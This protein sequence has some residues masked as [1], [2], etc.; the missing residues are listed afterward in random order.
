MAQELAPDLRHPLGFDIVSGAFKADPFPTLAAMRDAG[1][2]IPIRLPFVGRVWLATT[3]AACLAMVKDNELFVQEGRHAGRSGVPGFAWWLPKPLKVMTNNM[4]QKDE[5]DHR[6][7]RH[8]VDKAFA[9]RDVLAMRGGIERIADGLIDGFEGRP[10]VDLVEAYA[11]QLPMAVICDL[12][13]LTDEDR[14]EF[15]AQ[16]MKVLNI[17]SSLSLLMT[18]GAFNRML[19]HARRL[20][21]AARHAPRPGLI[22][23]LVAAEEAGDRLNAAELLSMIVLLLVAGFETTRQLIADSV[24]LLESQP[25][26]KAWLL[27]DPT[28]RMERAVEELARHASPVQMTKPRYISRDTD[29]FGVSLK[30][31]DIIMA[32]LAGA[33]SDPAVF[34][35]PEALRLDRFP[36][37]HLVFSSGVHFCLGMQLARVEAQSAVGRL[38]ARCPDL[39]LADPRRIEW[40]ERLGVRGPKALPVVLRPGAARLAA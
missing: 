20:I 6:R 12:L 9:R 33:N 15:S 8:L 13:G 22:A 2:V 25:D 27:A 32:L 18:A 14:I 16:A 5:P 21:E 29:F 40:I 34:D 38:Y 39:R 23:E 19:D 3:H 26:Q 31:G 24:I 11:R 28:E 35:A 7:L 4:L 36:N 30:R 10:T 37:P 1:P 17:T